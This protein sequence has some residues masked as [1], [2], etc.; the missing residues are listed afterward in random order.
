M[1][2]PLLVLTP[3][4]LAL[5][6]LAFGFVGCAGLLGLDEVAYAPMPTPPDA[7]F[8]LVATAQGLDHVHLEWKHKSPASVTFYV[9]RFGG[10][11]GLATKYRTVPTGPTSFDDQGPADVTEG[12]TYSY[13]ITAA[14]DD[15]ET[16]SNGATART[17]KWEDGYVGSLAALDAALAGDT[18][19]QRIDKAQYLGYGG[20]TVLKVRLTLRGSRNANPAQ[21]LQLD[22]VS[23][24]HEA[25]PGDPL[26]PTPQAWDSE[27]VLPRMVALGPQ[28][29]PG[30]GT[31]VTLPEVD[32]ALD[33]TRDLI[34]AYDIN[35]ANANQT[36]VHTGASASRAFRRSGQRPN[37]PEALKTDRSAGYLARPVDTVY[38][39]EKIEVLTA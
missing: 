27:P 39:V 24:S 12:T 31:P 16:L 30:T 25:R 4:L 36:R 23:L 3:L 18:L 20:T 35:P 10:P 37:A 21:G 38:L 7:P 22:Q 14:N 1:D 29:L 28:V 11:R 9:N 13:T 6:V 2:W 8:D 33:R 32:F 26:N 15:G 5:L 17:W 19:V 34:V